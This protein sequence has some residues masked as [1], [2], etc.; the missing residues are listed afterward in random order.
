MNTATIS[1][2]GTVKMASSTSDVGALKPRA[3]SA[4]ATKLVQFACG[5]TAQ[6]GTTMFPLASR[7]RANTAVRCA[8]LS[9]T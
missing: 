7:R 2:P 6:F 1:S 3:A 5:V 9:V 4:A 8:V